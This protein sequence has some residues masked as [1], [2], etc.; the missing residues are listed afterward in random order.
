VK[1]KKIKKKVY[2][3]FAADILYVRSINILKIA[4]SYGIEIIKKELDFLKNKKT[5]FQK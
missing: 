1:K 2:I 5:K 3:G 4:R